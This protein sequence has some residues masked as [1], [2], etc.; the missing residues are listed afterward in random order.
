VINLFPHF[1]TTSHKRQSS[2]VH[3][4]TKV[5]MSSINLADKFLSLSL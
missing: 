5:H 2:G 4:T 1:Q 3:Y